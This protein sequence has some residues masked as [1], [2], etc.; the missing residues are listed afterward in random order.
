MTAMQPLLIIVPR[1]SPLVILVG[2]RL[3]NCRWV[4]LLLHQLTLPGFWIASANHEYRRR[5]F[6]RGQNQLISFA[7]HQYNRRGSTRRIPIDC[8]TRIADGLHE[9]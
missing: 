1:I 7:N 2:F 8:G 4:A 6:K 3:L 9:Y 5:G